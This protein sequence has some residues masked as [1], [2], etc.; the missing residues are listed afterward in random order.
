MQKKYV[1]AIFGGAVA[2]SEAAELMKAFGVNVILFD[3]NALPYGKIESGLPKWHVKLRDKLEAKIDERLTDH[4]IRYIPSV[5][6]GQ[7]VAFKEICKTWGFNAIILATGAWKDRALPIDGVET[8]LG[9]N[10]YYQNPFVQW[11]NWNHDPAMNAEQIEISSNAIVIGGGLASIDV[12]KIIM[13]E[14]FQKAIKRFDKEMDTITI[15][16]LGLQEAANQLGIKFEDL[17]LNKCRIV[18]RRRIVDMPLSPDATSDDPA[19]IEKVHNVRK[20]I[21]NKASEKFYFEV[22]ECRSP[23]KIVE[24]DG[25]LV[26]L[27]CVRN[28]IENGRAAMQ[29]NSTHI[30]NAD[31]FVSSIGSIPEP[32]EGI[33][34]E[35]EG[36]ELLSEGIGLLKGG[37]HTFVI[38]NAITGKGN[39]KESQ[40]HAKKVSEAIIRD[41]LGVN[42]GGEHESDFEIKTDVAKQVAHIIKMI[43][44]V[45]PVSEEVLDSINKKVDALQ[46]KSGYD[47]NYTAWIKKHLP[48]R[49]ENET[50]K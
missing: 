12:A 27:E 50:K 49:L 6:L 32:I 1:V 18:Y 16:K 33:T 4:S 19:A 20:K 38:G 3:Q 23:Y 29:K 13:V 14:A 22:L 15:E 47:G 35:G 30:L 42:K 48:K 41:Y 24:E 28:N 5:K 9:K 37:N 21:V 44:K 43:K 11:Y 36:F 17:A 25:K 2:G 7:D 34:K 8:H 46:K 39:I 45:E 26:G 10:F 40:K 31:L